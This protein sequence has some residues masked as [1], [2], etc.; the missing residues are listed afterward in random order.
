MSIEP[1]N[2]SGT[3]E[4]IKVPCPKGRCQELHDPR[5]CLGHK[6]LEDGTLVPCKKFPSAGT[7]VC[8]FHGAAAPQVQKAIAVAKVR[9]EITEAVDILGA[10][11]ITDPLRALQELAGQ[12][13]EWKDALAARV[14][15]HTLR[16]ESAI[17]TEQ[18]RGEVVLLE[19]AM[20]RCNTVLATIA[21]L[22][23][24]ERLA[25][26]DELTAQMIVKAL[27]AGLAS[28]GVSGPAAVRAR[29]VTRG[30]LKV[31]AGGGGQ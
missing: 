20:D 3:P 9:R 24:D 19:R 4:P 10:Q 30:H 28:A 12:V 16:Y 25:R 8:R 5:K 18:V 1:V 31:L 7:T 23:I 13:V 15:L 14:D 21:K 6:D 17:S 26:I 11:P 22:N 2:G 29:E 27:E